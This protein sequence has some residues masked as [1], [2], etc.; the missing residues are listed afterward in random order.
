MEN[1]DEHNQF[2][3]GLMLVTGGAAW[4]A[5]NLG[6]VR[7]DLWNYWPLVFVIIGLWKLLHETVLHS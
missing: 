5:Y 7:A 4:T 3:W 6:L 2:F 1:H